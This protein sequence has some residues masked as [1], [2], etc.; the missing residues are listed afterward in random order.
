MSKHTRVCEYA[1][2]KKSRFIVSVHSAFRPRLVS[3]PSSL[4]HY[5][6][7]ISNDGCDE[8]GQNAD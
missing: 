4:N 7:A 3:R 5:F 8:G 2:K 1:N 6:D